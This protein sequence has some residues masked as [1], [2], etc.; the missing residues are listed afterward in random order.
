VRP[1]S[2]VR[3]IAVAVA[4]GGLALLTGCG[5]TPSLTTGPADVTERGE[6]VGMASFYAHA[7]HGRRT[8]SGERYDMHALTA[9]HRS[10]PFGT[11]LRVTNL[12]NGRSVVVRVNDRGPYRKGRVVDVSLAAAKKL[13][14]VKRGVARVK[15]EVL[16]DPFAGP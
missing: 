16:K 5:T 1:F 10:L 14:L 4:W 13:G 7:H 8:A 9:A 15:V 3:A 6:Q 2:L 12:A 11:D